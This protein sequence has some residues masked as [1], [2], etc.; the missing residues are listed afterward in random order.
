MKV[1][2]EKIYV[3]LAIFT[4]IYICLVCNI[5]EPFVNN[6]DSAFL[7]NRLNQIYNCFMDGKYPFLYYNDFLG[8]G[9]G[10]SI[11]YGQLTLFPFLPFVNAGMKPFLMCYIMV[12][13]ILNYLGSCYLASKFTENSKLVGLLYITSSLFVQLT[14]LTLTY[15]S[16][17][18]VGI[19]LFFL[20]EC[21]SVFRDNKSFSKASLLFLILFNTHTLTSVVAFIVCIMLL[22]YYRKRINIKNCFWFASLTVLLCSYNIVNYLYH[23]ESLRTLSNINSIFSFEDYPCYVLDTIPVGGGISLSILKNYS[24]LKLI[25]EFLLV[26]IAIGVVSSIKANKKYLWLFILSIIGVVISISPVWSFLYKIWKNPIQFPSRFLPVLLVFLLILSFKYFKSDFL[27]LILVLFCILDVIVSGLIPSQKAE[28]S[29][30]TFKYVGNGEYLSDNFIFDSEVFKKYSNNVIGDDGNTYSY[31]IDKDKITI[32]LETNTSS[33]VTVPKLY[34]KGYVADAEKGGQL[35]CKEGYSMF[36]EIN[37]EGY[38]GKLIVYYQQPILL[39][40]LLVVCYSASIT[41]VLFDIINY[42]RKKN[43]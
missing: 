35:E 1:K 17:L 19:A 29:Y 11:F 4:I 18:G 41:T 40:Y 3:G 23:I 33:S 13:V 9:Y 6:S 10:S 39:I 22:I 27:K 25:N 16:Y 7:W 34:Y 24:G 38:V 31:E 43:L 32:N 26:A 12:Y 5:S 14:M 8:V 42:L 21:V 30:D 20:G 15:T 28:D 37:V 2:Y 36:T